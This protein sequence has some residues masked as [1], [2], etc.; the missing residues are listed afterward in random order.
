[1][2]GVVMSANLM[3]SKY[4]I[5]MQMALSEFDGRSWY[6]ILHREE[7]EKEFAKMAFDCSDGWSCYMP[8]VVKKLKQGCQE[9]NS[10]E[11]NGRH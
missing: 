10:T 7:D 9:L 1:M 11:Q 3:N 6:D 4:L 8:K 5:D 2:I